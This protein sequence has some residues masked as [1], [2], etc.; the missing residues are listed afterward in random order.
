MQPPALQVVMYHYVRDL[1]RTPF[2]RIK[3]MLTADFRS[4]VAAL[5]ECYE[6]ATLESALNYT[7]PISRPLFMSTNGSPKP[8]PVLDVILYIL[9][10]AGQRLV[11][12]VGYAPIRDE[13]F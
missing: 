3:G 6:M 11:L 7:Y 9:S 5:C 12:E 10:D 13:E 1:P 2:P 4:Q 8:G